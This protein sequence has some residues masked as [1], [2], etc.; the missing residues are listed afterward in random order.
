MSSLGY[1]LIILWRDR[2]RFLPAVLAVV[3]SAVLIAGQ[4]GMLLGLLLYTSLPIDHASADVWITTRDTQSLAGAHPIPE[5]QLHRLADQPEVVKAEP[6]LLGFGSWHL[7]GE[8]ALEGCIV[9]GTRLEEGSIGVV[10]E[11][12]PEARKRLTEPGTVVVDEWE[13]SK[14]GLKRGVDEF[15]EINQCR[16]RVVGTISGF[17]GF[18]APYVFCSLQTAR[19][20]LPTLGQCPQLTTYVLGRCQNRYDAPIVVERL[21]ALYPD[22]GAYTSPEFSRRVQAYW[23]F[24]SKGGTVMGCTVLLALAVGLAITRQTLYAAAVAS[25]REYAMLDALGIPRWRLHALV[26]ASS[27][28]IGLAGV[29]CALPVAFGLGWA[30]QLVQVRI[31]LPDWLLGGTLLLTMVMALASGVSALRSLRQ[32]D[33]DLLLR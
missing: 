24:R 21:R 15:A 5:V 8:G 16:V 19:R 31:L 29:A 33:P 12:S 27:F 9:I 10:H 4:C 25:L 28:W 2:N 14:L 22:M 11:L 1:A 26:L 13:L 30:A 17:E 6:Y 32:V 3:F 23:L 7:P 18:T 20:L